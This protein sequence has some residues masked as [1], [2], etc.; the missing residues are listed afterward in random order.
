MVHRSRPPGMPLSS[1]IALWKDATRG[2]R[3]IELG[4]GATGVLLSLAST[5]AR[6]RAADGRMPMDN[7]TGL[8][9]AGVHQVV[10]GS[11]P[12]STASSEAVT[13]AALGPAELTI[14]S[15]WADAVAAA[16]TDE[17]PDRLEAILADAAPG[18]AWRR[19]LGLPEPSETLTR[20]IAAVGEA[21]VDVPPN[22]GRR[23][24]H[25]LSAIYGSAGE[26]EPPV[27]LARAVL[28]R[29][30]EARIDLGSAGRRDH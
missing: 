18:A 25:V 4:S 17:D 15:S 14:A 28:A 22:G 21:A 23:D 5:R 16:L 30:L 8:T 1:V 11:T 9:V 19:R 7:A 6:R 2:L 20:A 24:L 12:Q 13:G 29:A 10:T 27:P 26:G 3:E